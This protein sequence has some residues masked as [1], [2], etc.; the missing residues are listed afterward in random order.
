MSKPT[1][2][3]VVHGTQFHCDELTAVALLHVFKPEFEYVISRIPHQAPIPE[4]ADYVIDVGREFDGVTKFDHHQ[5]EHGK[6]SAG[7]LWDHV[8]PA[9]STYNQLDKFIELIDQHDVGLRPATAFEYP[10]IIAHFNTADIYDTAAQMDAFKKALQVAITVIEGIKSGDESAV[11]VERYLNTRLANLSTWEREQHVLISNRW[12]R[13]WNSTLNGEL[14][15]EI[16]YIIWPK[17][18]DNPT[19]EWQIQVLTQHSSTYALHGP[20]L[21]PSDKMTFVHSNGFFGVA[22]TKFELLAYIENM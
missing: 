11:E 15:P 4:L 5:W 1:K 19:G 8:K 22:P 13:G 3:V 6:S 9:G 7:L 10:R 16:H 2:I 21:E 20:R 18:Q 12:L 14:T 17:E